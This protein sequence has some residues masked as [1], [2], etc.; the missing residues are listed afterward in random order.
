MARDTMLF[1]TSVFH[2]HS[3]VDFTS[4][5]TEKWNEAQ[6]RAGFAQSSRLLLASPGSDAHLLIPWV[7]LCQDGECREDFE[8][9]EGRLGEA[10]R[11]ESGPFLQ[12]SLRV[13]CRKRGKNGCIMKQLLI[14]CAYS[15]GP[16][17]DNTS[18]RSGASC[19]ALPICFLLFFML[20][21]AYHLCP[22]LEAHVWWPIPCHVI[23][24][25]CVC[26][27]GGGVVVDSS[28]AVRACVWVDSSSL[29]S[30]TGSAFFCHQLPEYTSSNHSMHIQ[31]A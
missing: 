11:L 29:S 20:I 12:S 25:L 8:G 5:F 1:C 2:S 27:G 10:I 16:P 26:V 18:A 22:K 15:L 6:Q 28:Q 24:W 13:E 17:E 14:L 9:K 19:M 3:I 23:V 21:P 30:L 31:S 4:Q 7:G